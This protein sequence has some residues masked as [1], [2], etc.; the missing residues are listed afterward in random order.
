M[1]FIVEFFCK[2]V[3]INIFINDY[4]YNDKMQKNRFII[5]VQTLKLYIVMA[6][7]QI[8][9]KF[10]NLITCI[11]IKDSNK[12]FNIPPRPLKFSTVSIFVPFI[13]ISK[14]YMSMS[15][16]HT[17]S[18]KEENVRKSISR[19]S[20]TALSISISSEIIDQNEP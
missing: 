9:V 15:N 7:W 11:K 1:L 19:L 4:V 13:F 16:F 8:I 5:R 17:I 12:T 14:T 6:S 10:K 2:K 3:F 18:F 20:K